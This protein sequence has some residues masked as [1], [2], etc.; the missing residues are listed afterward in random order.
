LVIHSVAP[1][2]AANMADGRPVGGLL[3]RLAEIGTGSEF[4]RRTYKTVMT[5]V[6]RMTPSPSGMPRVIT[7]SPSGVESQGLPKATRRMK[8]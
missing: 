5:M 8:P 6:K 7:P 4:A 2:K 1:T 3:L